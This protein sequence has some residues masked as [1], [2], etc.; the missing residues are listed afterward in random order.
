M[1]GEPVK[2]EFLSS[3]TRFDDT[4]GDVIEDWAGEISS[5]TTLEATLD[6]DSG[7][8]I[9]VTMEINVTEL[10]TL[11]IWCVSKE[12]QEKWKLEFN[13][14]EKDNGSV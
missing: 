6:G 2:F 9:P 12:N 8:A 14:R 4:I 5:I 1:I 11:E 13:V 7:T 10:G 3:S